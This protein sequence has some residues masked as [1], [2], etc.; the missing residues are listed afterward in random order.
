MT[1]DGN[2]DITDRVLNDKGFTFLLAA[3]HLETADDSRL[4]MIN[5]V[6]EYAEENDIP[7]YC[8]TASGEKAMNRWQA[9]TGAEYPFCTTDP[10]TLQT[11][12]RSNPGLILIENGTV[13]G[14][15]SCNDL[16]DENSLTG[17][18]DNIRAGNTNEHSTTGK[19]AFIISIYRMDRA[20][21]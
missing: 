5:A 8:L 14:K 13:A 3:P 6:Y 10:T 18:L 21:V 12:I 11:M 4:D 15:W 16:P 9:I 17:I 20:T 1:R 7:F 2:E 19:V